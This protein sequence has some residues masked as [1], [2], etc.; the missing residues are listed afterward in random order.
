MR[1]GERENLVV[2]N[3]TENTCT[4]PHNDADNRNSKRYNHI[5][6]VSLHRPPLCCKCKTSL[7]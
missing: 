1:K 2:V 5:S 4:L 3:L 6:F 7:I